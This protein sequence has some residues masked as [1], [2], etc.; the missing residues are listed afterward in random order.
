MAV[1]ARLYDALVHSIARFVNDFFKIKKRG[2][3]PLSNLRFFIYE[4][5][6]VA[7]HCARPR[8]GTTVC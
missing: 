4:R 8:V 5:D 6:R 7:A 3:T 1:V 2:S